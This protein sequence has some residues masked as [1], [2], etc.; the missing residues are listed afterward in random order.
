MFFNT[1]AIFLLV[2]NWKK[3]NTRTDFN[4]VNIV[5]QKYTRHD[6]FHAGSNDTDCVT[7]MPKACEAIKDTELCCVTPAV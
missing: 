3:N 4:H 6:G 1:R 5:K 7:E 2:E